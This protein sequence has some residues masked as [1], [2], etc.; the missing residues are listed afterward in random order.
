MLL[1][2]RN[3][4]FAQLVTLSIFLLIST[5]CIGS[6]PEIDRYRTP[7][8][9][10]ADDAVSKWSL[11]T[12]HTAQAGE[13]DATIDALLEPPIEDPAIA[14]AIDRFVILEKAAV[15]RRVLEVERLLLETDPEKFDAITADQRSLL[16]DLRAA[17][18]PPK[19]D[20]RAAD[21]IESAID[22]WIKTAEAAEAASRFDEAN[23]AWSAVGSIAIGSDRPLILV[24]ARRRQRRLSSLQPRGR[25]SAPKDAFGTERPTIEDA[26]RAFSAI[27]K[28][29]VDSPTW[30]Q[31]C[32]AGFDQIAEAIPVLMEASDRA[33]GEEAVAHARSSFERA[34]AGIEARPGNLP[35]R[36][37]RAVK[38]SLEAM[39]SASV[40]T[41]LEPSVVARLFLDGAIAA[42]DLR[43]N[44]YFGPQADQVRRQLEATF[45]GIGTELRQT[46]EGVFLRPISG[47]PAARA[48]VRGGDR[49]LAVD[50]KDVKGRSL[51]SIVGLVSGPT[52]TA[53]RLT[54]SR[55]D[56][57]EPFELDVT[58]EEVEREAVLGW[59]QK[60]VEADGRP[61]WDWLIDADA[62]IAFISIR[63]FRE[64]VIHRFRSAFREASDTL[65]P[66]R[67]VAGLILDLRDDPGGLRWVAEDLLDLFLSRGTI[68]SAEGRRAKIE[69]QSAS[70]FRTRLEGLP[71]VVLVNRSS[72]SASEIVAGTLQ[73][74]GGAVVVGER[75]HGKGSVQTVRTL[76]NNGY[77]FVTESWFTVPDGDG[78][79]RLID[80]YRAGKDWGIE[81]DL[82]VGETTGETMKLMSER[83]RWHSGRGLD[84]RG[85]QNTSPTLATTTDR[86]LLLAVAL[87][88]ARLLPTYESIEWQVDSEGTA[89]AAEVQ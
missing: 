39:G 79:R 72:A 34:T 73:A 54:L 70:S 75:T 7:A 26:L 25:S 85:A 86:E 51:D 3:I 41:P 84:V 47:S 44:A 11:S 31:L 8:S 83:G 57:D 61:I 17:G 15:A 24:E 48:G 67:S 76:F 88:R 87:L 52:N 68:F 65:G 1:R 50:G 27:L 21:A 6:G 64:D 29:H 80:R 63:E 35:S 81:P 74:V 12:W 71:V 66:D 32:D 20:Q 36:V 49:L 19:T 16:A 30:K 2:L 60:G 10:V 9:F 5:G 82:P 46:P 23:D 28:F 13:L 78:G 45:F 42:T 40:R 33:E 37:R 14:S 4:Q 89:Q 22:A 69:S 18:L 77:A 58:R 59:R 62:G 55:E 53:V 38:S 43:T 56:V